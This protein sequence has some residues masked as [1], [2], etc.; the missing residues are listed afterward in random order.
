MAKASSSD[1]PLLVPLT[2]ATAGERAVGGKARQLGRLGDRGMRVPDGRVVTTDALLKT[3]AEAGLRPVCEAAARALATGDGERARGAGRAAADALKT[4]PL[5]RALDEALAEAFDA[6]G[7]TCAVRSSA[8][9]EDAAD[10]SHAGQFE[11]VLNLRTA[12]EVR[13]AVRAVWAS[14]YSD[15]AIGYRL[16]PG[17]PDAGVVVPPMAVLVQRMV[18]PR[19]SGILFTANPVSGD[20]GEMM[21]EAGP[22]L[23]E[24]L[25]QGVI[26]PDFFLVDRAGLTIAERGIAAK[27]RRLV[28]LPEGGG[29]V[30]F[31]PLDPRD[32]NRACLGDDEVAALCELGLRIEDEL[33]GPVDVE[34]S[35]D[36][37]GDIHVL[38][39]RPV[40]AIPPSRRTPPRKRP[41][42]W[43]QR[44]SG[45]RWTEQA[46]PLGWS[47]V[48]PVLHWFTYWELAADRYLDGTLP[49]RLYRGRP[50]FNVTI[51]RHLAFRRPGGAPPHFLLEMF[52]PEEQAALA[53]GP[54]LP[55]AGLVASIFWQVFR[56][57]RWKRYRYNFL[58][59]HRQWEEFRPGFEGRTAALPT[60]FATP[61]EG[62]AAI[63]RGRALMVEY[64]SIHLL[65]L[66]FAHLTYE[67][68]DR[69]LVSWVGVE[70]EAIR[71]ALVA[72]PA[73]NRTL[74]TN[75]ALW[76]LSRAARRHP[77]LEAAL[78]RTPVPDLD[79]LA[80]LPG[81]TAFRAEFDRFVER[82]GHRSQASYE[83][84]AT[85]WADSPELVLKLVAGYVRGGVEEPPDR[86]ES[87][88]ARERAQAERLV[89]E[90]MT[91]TLRR[92]V[93]PWR[94]AVFGQLLDLTRRYMALREN[95]RFSFDRLLLR[96]KRIFERIGALM[97][98][99]G[100]LDAGDDLVFLTIDEVT[101]VADG[102]LRP[103]EAT[104]LAATR[105]AEFEAN[106]D[107]VHPD[108]LE[109]DRHVA[110]AGVAPR[111]GRELIGQ[112]ISPGVARG[113]VRVLRSF[114]A[115]DTL[116]PG[117]ILVARATD[118]GWTP[119][120]LVASALVLE[121]GSVL[122][123]GAVVAREY[124][125]PAV[126]NVEGAT[127]LL[128]D[129]DEV[130]VDGSTGRI[131]L[132]R[133]AMNP[134]EAAQDVF[135]VG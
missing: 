94:Q 113:R 134:E 125:L 98:R 17:V 7:G 63:E 129:G 133:A 28:P 44:F 121:L 104:G 110:S 93:L 67:A 59:N 36:D 57:R 131:V 30:G 126:V 78:C 45:E 66:L 25:A 5:P 95:Q 47:I 91:R 123:H 21:L 69:A 48:Q 73:E 10:R 13:D 119:L 46:T 40:T 86:V 6:L 103:D 20:R 87:R 79:D 102:R 49:T 18:A 62:L 24:A 88:R 65:S 33:G 81:G 27:D 12:G 9:G 37:R 107:L 85:R 58:T 29:A 32:R 56:E 120:F 101:G 96:M 50:Y 72:D 8:V 90:R 2:P 3:I 124:G 97:E 77:A 76:E 80:T 15:R 60:D 99:D 83:I 118:P 61:A 64:M 92:R 82:F 11:S 70:G 112:P 34:W 35:I 135:S 55:N 53:E 68:L 114:H 39:A 100:L 130:T 14:W 105:R 52:P 89:R 106:R 122:S 51:F 117:E 4:V 54:L 116:Q 128:Q 71:S 1:A 74:Q 42:L 38:Q 23:G 26:H 109:A 132:H 41:V 108:F 19:A 31:E 16:G 22:G 43:T 127:R 111:G 115:M 75:K 84:F